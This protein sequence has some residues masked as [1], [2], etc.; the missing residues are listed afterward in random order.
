MGLGFPAAEQRVWGVG[1]AHRP[2]VL[3]RGRESATETIPPILLASSATCKIERP[4]KRSDE[5]PPEGNPSTSL[6][7]LDFAAAL[8]AG[9]IGKGEKRWARLRAGY[10]VA[11]RRVK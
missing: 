2:G 7:M 4:E 3:H 9:E 8:R 5:G 10:P 6:R 1:N 11:L